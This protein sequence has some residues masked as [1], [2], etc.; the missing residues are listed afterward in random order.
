M[1]K[2]RNMERENRWLDVSELRIYED[3]TTEKKAS[4]YIAGLQN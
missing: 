3:I 2:F 1:Y 4:L